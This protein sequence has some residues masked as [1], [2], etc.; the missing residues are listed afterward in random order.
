MPLSVPLLVLAMF[1]GADSAGATASNPQVVFHT[2]MGDMVIELWPD[3]APKTVENFLAYANSGF[4]QGTI[5]HR[6]IPGFVIQGG[7]FDVDMLQKET[8]LPIQNE[9]DDE[10][11]NKR[12]TL[13]MARTSNPHSATSQFFVNLRDNVSL[14]HPSTGSGWGYAVFG[15]VVEGMDVVDAIA[16]VETG[17]FGMHSDVPLKPLVVEKVTVR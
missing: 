7:G 14:D 3:K 17:R 13:S 15:E 12:G 5:F 8:K 10:V 2:A 6:V 16:G 9:A 4:Y 1:A 11:K